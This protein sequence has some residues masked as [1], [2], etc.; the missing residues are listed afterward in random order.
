MNCIESRQILE[1]PL[2][3]INNH[4]VARITDQII[5]TNQVPV[6][7][8]ASRVGTIQ[9]D[10]PALVAQAGPAAQFAWE[11]FI[12]GKIRNPHTRK[13]YER[14]I[15]QFLRHCES[16]GRELSQVSP[17]D[18]GSYLDGLECAV[19]TKKLHLSALRHFFDVL[20]TS[21]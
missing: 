5:P 21:V 6:R 14:A 15:R 13:A 17:K 7:V 12:F 11:E 19:A 10:L 1:V 9:C 20:V 3:G 8:C 18:V 16:L 2:K 4:S